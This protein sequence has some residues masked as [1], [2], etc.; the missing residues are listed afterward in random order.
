MN[1]ILDNLSHSN[2][3]SAENV[4]LCFTQTYYFVTAAYQTVVFHG[5]DKESQVTDW[6]SLRKSPRPMLNIPLVSD[7]MDD[8]YVKFTT[9][10]SLQPQG[11]SSIASTFG[12]SDLKQESSPDSSD[13]HIYEQLP[14]E[15]I[16]Q[17]MPSG[18]YVCNSPVCECVTN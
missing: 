17:I 12:T 4:S 11:S 5:Q 10:Q 13:D 14:Y 2:H 1:T 6:A 3:R 9:L 8:G 15:R 16:L 18:K 7:N